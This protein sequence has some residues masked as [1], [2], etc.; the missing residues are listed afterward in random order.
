MFLPLILGFS[1]PADHVELQSLADGVYAAVRREPPGLAVDCNVLFIVSQSDVVMVDANIGPESTAATLAALRKVT[2]KP[3]STIIATH[4]HDDHM[5]GV[6]TI[7]AQNPDAELVAHTSAVSAIEELL[8]P[9]RKGMIDIAPQMSALLKDLIA[10]ERSYGGW[11]LTREERVSYENDIRIAERY[12][13]EMPAIPLPKPD[14]LVSD[15][16]VLKR[17]DRTIE[18]LHLGQGHTPSDLVVWLPK[19]QIAASGDLLV[20]PVPLVGD[21][22]SNV[23]EWPT[24]LDRLAALSP[25]L[26]LP[27][28]GPVMHNTG[29]LRQMSA[30]FT[31]VTDEVRAGMARGETLQQMTASLKFEEEKAGFCGNSKLREVLFEEYVRRPSI[32]AAHRLLAE[33]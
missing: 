27:G 10:K 14:R 29:Y 32:A 15:R 28:H 24:T 6:A 9:A 4:Y 17:G 23:V 7:K 18:I 1:A 13:V 8:K 25:R 3:I 22:Q 31:T 33:N 20:W 26:I 5:G 11:P 19:E 2:D 12:A 21:K 16:L 30:F